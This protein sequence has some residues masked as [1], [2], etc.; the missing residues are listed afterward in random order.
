MKKCLKKYIIRQKD[1]Y[2]GKNEDLTEE[3]SR[4]CVACGFFVVGKPFIDDLANSSIQ[5]F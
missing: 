2:M 4:V 5:T 3:L 1:P